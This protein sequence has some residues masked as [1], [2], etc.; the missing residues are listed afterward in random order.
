MLEFVPS[1]FQSYYNSE[2]IQYYSISTKK[3]YN[4]PE[5]NNLPSAR[6][7]VALWVLSAVCLNPW[8]PWYNANMAAMFA[9]RAWVETLKLSTY[10][11]THTPFLQI[12]EA[13]PEQCRCCW[14]L[15]PCGCAALWSGEPD[16]KPLYQ[17]HL[18]NKKHLT[19]DTNADEEKYTE[20]YK[21]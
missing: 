20:F 18:C 8:G 19:V 3:I 15:C 7:N 16:D 21:L 14:W 11:Y 2:N 9:R 4:K 6:I 13:L 1:S 17:P 12:W 5:S 10:I